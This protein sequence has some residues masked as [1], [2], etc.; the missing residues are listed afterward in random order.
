MSTNG[1][2]GGTGDEA[3]EPM[4]Q[5]FV[6]FGL[7]AAAVVAAVGVGI[8]VFASGDDGRTTMDPAG[9]PV[10]GVGV[11]DPERPEVGERV[12]DF[13][14][15]D[16]RAPQVVRRLSDYR[17]R[18]IVL[19]FYASWCLPCRREIP[20][21][22]AA[23][24]GLGDSVVFL[25]I[26]KEESRDLA[27]GI[28]EEFDAKYPAL[29]DSDGAIARHWRVG[30]LPVTFFIDADFVLR[31]IRLGEVSEAVLAAQLGEIGLEWSGEAD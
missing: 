31:G 1:A 5:R 17:G 6:G 11:I 30:G 4:L 29:L 18:P 7:L 21:F 13:A 19:N 23:Q 22:Q 8:Y 20:A 10:A 24:E 14:L 26:N 3:P 25:G 9:T 28:L 12:P 27:V 2:S 15:A 16:A